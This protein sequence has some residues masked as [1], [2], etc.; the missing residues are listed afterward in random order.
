M[1]YMSHSAPPPGT[2]VHTWAG[3]VAPSAD[4]HGFGDTRAMSFVPLVS[5]SALR[6]RGR[7]LVPQTPEN[8][9]SPTACGREM[10]FTSLIS[11][12]YKSTPY[13]SRERR[14]SPASVRK[15]AL[16]LSLSGGHSVVDIADGH[17]EGSQVGNAT[18]GNLQGS[19]TDPS[20][21]AGCRSQRSD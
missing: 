11:G 21:G 9:L 18:L 20:G 2:F 19:E 8:P 5:L 7:L 15:R 14:C 3:E 10:V 13:V 4:G 6:V 16:V 1:I 12:L 17:P